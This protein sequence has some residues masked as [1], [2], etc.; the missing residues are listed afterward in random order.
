MKNNQ[1]NIL[2]LSPLYIVLTI[3]MWKSSHW[4]VRYTDKR[5]LHKDE[6]MDWPPR[7]NLDNVE[8][9]CNTIQSID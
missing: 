3:F 5:K 8:T 6:Y 7:H 9:A 2:Y 4:L 1:L